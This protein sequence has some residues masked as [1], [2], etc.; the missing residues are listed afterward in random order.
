MLGK[1]FIIFLWFFIYIFFLLF[2]LINKTIIYKIIILSLFYFYII[3]VLSL[4]F[5]PVP[6]AWLEEIWRYQS[7]KNNFIPFVSLLE[8]LWNQNWDIFIKSKQIIWNIILFIPLWFFIHLFFKEKTS[9]QKILFIGFLLS[10]SIEFLQ[11]I[12]WN[13]LWFFYRS[14]DIDDILLN[15]FGFIIW[16]YISKF[17]H[18]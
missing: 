8:I 13:I 10:F 16:A 1:D 4:T 6:I 15:S 2:L 5:F 17:L 12:I 14:S 9:F 7:V 3:I 11:Y 18:K